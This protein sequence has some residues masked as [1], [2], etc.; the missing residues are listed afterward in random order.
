MSYTSGDEGNFSNGPDLF[1]AKNFI[2][3][4]VVA[5]IGIL[6]KY[7]WPEVQKDQAFTDALAAEVAAVKKQLPTKVDEMTEMTDISA[8]GLHVTYTYK[9]SEVLN[10]NLVA[11][12]RSTM[13]NANSAQVCSNA[14]MRQLMLKDGSVT[15]KYEDAAGTKFEAT[16]NS[17]TAR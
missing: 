7:Y 10:P 5:G 4:A 17:C 3:V 6:A 13:K 1:T 16:I 12:Y 11:N 2:R 15:F 8:K 9:I 14:N